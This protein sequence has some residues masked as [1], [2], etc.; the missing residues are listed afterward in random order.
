MI[1][2]YFGTDGIRGEFGGS[3]INESFFRRIGYAIGRYLHMKYGDKSLHVAIVR[4]TR[5][6]GELLEQALLEG[7]SFHNVN[8]FALGVLPTPA[9]AMVVRELDCDLGIALT[10]S[11]NPAGDNGIKLFNSEALKL[12]DKEEVQLEQLIDAEPERPPRDIA[13][14]TYEYDGFEHYV[15]YV[16]SQIHQGSLKGWKIVC[17]TAHGATYRTTPTTLSMLGAEVIQ[18]GAIPDGQN[19]NRDVGSEHPEAMAKLVKETGANLGIAHDGDGD[20]LIVCDENGKVLDGDEVLAIIGLAMLKDKQLTK[21]SMVATIMSNL[22]L[23]AAINAAGGKVIRTPVGDRHVIFEL[24][25]KGLNFGG[26]AS[27]HIVYGDA[28]TT[29]DGLLAALKLCAV[30]LD[31][32]KPLSVLRKQMTLYPQEKR[33]LRVKE[34][35]PIE[36]LTHLNAVQKEVQDTLGAEARTLVRYSGTEPKIRLLVETASLSDAKKYIKKLEEAA[37]QDLDVI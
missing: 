8:V 16:R 35:L 23:D 6:S 31:T 3:L 33:N 9:V 27:G 22:G 5:A 2:K 19:I 21:K 20:R 37:R 14:K 30:M 25:D 28:S 11:H 34:K 32:S 1:R 4:D 15:N 24:Q 26:E 18:M 36:K 13:P 10:A 29:G 7:L 17:D 12:E